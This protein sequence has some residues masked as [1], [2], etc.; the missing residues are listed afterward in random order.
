MLGFARKLGAFL[1]MAALFSW[2]PAAIAQ[3]NSVGNVDPTLSSAVPTQGGFSNSIQEHGAWTLQVVNPDGS[4]GEVVH[5][6][7]SL[8]PGGAALLAAILSRNDSF[9]VWTGWVDGGPNPTD[10]SP[11]GNGPSGACSFEEPN[12]P[13]PGNQS[14]VSNNLMVS[15][16]GTPATVVL[17][18]E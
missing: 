1:A 11:C 14:G 4:L 18:A 7:N 6:E 2:T 10:I 3:S 5:A 17:T 13:L 12:G 9:G 16:N 15:S 8:D